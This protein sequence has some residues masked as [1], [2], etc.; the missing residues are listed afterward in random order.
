M[1]QLTEAFGGVKTRPYKRTHEKRTPI[2]HTHTTHTHTRTHVYAWTLVG[3]RTCL[4]LIGERSESDNVHTARG[5]R[6]TAD[7]DKL[8]LRA[9]GIP[10]IVRVDPGRVPEGGV[11]SQ[12]KHTSA[13]HKIF[14]GK[15]S[16]LR[17]GGQGT[18]DPSPS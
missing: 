2:P 9:R 16:L 11:L 14:G 1:L 6:P 13:A 17:V 8:N 12:N 15:R 7:T 10:T 18:L 3:C 5:H 4:E